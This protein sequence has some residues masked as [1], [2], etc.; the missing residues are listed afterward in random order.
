MPEMV[1]DGL[2]KLWTAL[3]FT[4]LM[5]VSC[6]PYGKDVREAL[7]H[8]GD[9]RGELEQVME[10]YSHDKSDSLKRKAALYLIGNMTWHRSYPAE[11][12]SRYCR[13]MDSVSVSDIPQDSMKQALE[14]ISSRYARSLVPVFDVRTVTADYLIWNIDYS[15]DVWE[16]TDWLRHLDF[17]QFCEYVLPYKCVDLQPLTKWKEEYSDVYR[18]ELDWIKPISEY[19]FNAR[20]AAEAVQERIK[21]SVRMERIPVQYIDIFDI[22]TLMHLRFGNCYERS[23][24]GLMNSR[25]KGIP[26]TMDFTPAWAD[27]NVNHHWNNVLSTRRRNIDFEP[28]RFR[29]GDFHYTDNPYAKVYRVTYHPSGRML[30]ALEEDRFLPSSLMPALFSEDVTAEYGKTKDVTVKVHRN[31]AGSRH[32]YLSVFN[33]ES[34]V[35]VDAGKIRSGKVSFHD[36]GVGLAYIVVMYEDGVQIPVTSPFI[37]DSRGRMEYVGIDREHLQDLHVLRKFPAFGHIY[38]V[39]KY[40]RQ[41]YIEA[42][43]N[44]EFANARFMTE[45]PEWDLLAGEVPVADTSAY[46]YWRLRCSH[47]S[48]SDFGELYFYERGSGRLLSGKL[49]TPGLPIRNHEYDTPEH[50]CDGDPL[51]YFAVVRDE[52]W[53]GFDFGR[54]V[55]VGEV[56]YIRRGDGNDICPGQVYELYYWDDGK[57][58]FHDRKTADRVYLDFEDVPSDALYYIK[59]ITTG[60]QNRIFLYEN[61]EQ[62][63]Y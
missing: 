17:R 14:E 11:A 19:R 7:R 34:W 29:P 22:R 36:V 23:V 44:P 16:N 8:A 10:H 24:L 58:V 18:G 28:F 15:F 40:L 39:R 53:V 20:M 27:R 62:I 25:S 33:N 12:Y 4:G 59:C 50:I 43:D 56:A 52:R 45:F 47:D 30:E 55:S 42:A 32:A 49:V 54:P 60:E 37:I 6:S 48:S 21:D 26:V 1:S 63:W 41:G 38:R 61:G 46:R 57:W 31:G 51:T 9:N 13:E 35:P 3:V 5:S 2:K